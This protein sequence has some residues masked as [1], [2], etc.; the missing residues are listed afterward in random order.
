M[1]IR[2]VFFDLDGTLWP[3][4]SVVLPAYRRVFQE[5][6]LPAPADE[7]L[8]D[9][10]GYQNED[11]WRRLLPES[12]Q[13]VWQ[14]ADRL[15]GQAEQD[16]ISSGQ[17]APFPG[18][19]D[20]LGKLYG[21]GCQLHI[22]S[23]CG[24]DYLRAVPNALG[25]GQFFTGRFCA[26]DFPGKSKAEIMAAVLPGMALPGA[27]VGDRWHDIAAGREN[28]LLTVGCQYGVGRPGEL[29]AADH[30]ISS[31]SELLSILA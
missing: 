26:G 3:P 9:T 22:L 13:A 1:R 24:P 29:T 8:L 18:V 7:V 19:V 6:S 30:L 28:G 31:F 11:I 5:L 23:N 15:M 21:A 25:I 2:T 10:L 14:Q 16:L 12:D 27:M 4:H 17:A 20:T